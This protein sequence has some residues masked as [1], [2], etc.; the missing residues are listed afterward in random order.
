MERESAQGDASYASETRGSQT[1]ESRR[2]NSR[3]GN[4]RRGNHVA[5]VPQTR[6]SRPA[7]KSGHEENTDAGISSASCRYERDTDAGMDFALRRY[8]NAKAALRSC[9]DAGV[10]SAS[11]ERK[12]ETGKDD[13]VGGGVIW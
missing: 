6:G 9:L 2:G 5:K 7:F 4:H 3:R 1:R 13:F 8:K 10:R 12:R 11:T